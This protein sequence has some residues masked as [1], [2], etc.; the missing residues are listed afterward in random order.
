MMGLFL[1]WLFRGRFCCLGLGAELVRLHVSMSATRLEELEV[2]EKKEG[3]QG[4]TS[5][6]STGGIYLVRQKTYEIQSY[7]EI[8]DSAEEETGPTSGGPWCGF[9]YTSSRGQPDF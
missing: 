2:R 5:N 6:R 1:A 8:I 9:T 4:G 7:G 3:L